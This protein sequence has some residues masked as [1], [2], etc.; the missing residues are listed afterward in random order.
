MFYLLLCI[1]S[2]VAPLHSFDRTDREI[3]KQ[4]EQLA[5]NS[6][7]VLPQLSSDIRA[8]RIG[9]VMQKVTISGEGVL[10]IEQNFICKSLDGTE[11][12]PGRSSQRFYLSDL[13]QK[14]P[15]K[16]Y[17]VN[18][19]V[20]TISLFYG[21]GLFVLSF[22]SE[23]D[24]EKAAK[25]LETLVMRAPQVQR[26]Q[27]SL[28]ELAKQCGYKYLVIAPRAQSY[29]EGF[30]LLHG[31]EQSPCL[32]S[33]LTK[34]TP[35]QIGSLLAESRNGLPLLLYDISLLDT[36][37]FYTQAIPH[38]PSFS[39][40]TLGEEMEQS[41][42]SDDMISLR[43]FF[44]KTPFAGIR[45]EKVPDFAAPLAIVCKALERNK[46]QK[47]ARAEKIQ[48]HDVTWYPTKV[49]HDEEIPRG[50]VSSWFTGLHENSD[51]ILRYCL[52]EEPL[53]PSI[54]SGTLYREFPLLESLLQCKG[55]YRKECS[56]FEGIVATSCAL[57][58]QQHLLLSSAI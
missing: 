44:E 49:L 16:R 2:V 42:V 6:L 9:P 39:T 45:F 24:L 17:E 52:L 10:T 51:D 15:N 26:V 13:K 31:G 37:P 34:H 21:K 47:Y 35:D 1:I 53:V 32:L 55:R 48:T 57:S 20:N 27:G 23:R 30:R 29:A 38:L 58:K 33:W 46:L 3:A 36:V 19:H 5:T 50:T 43:A 7:G 22:S 11:K 41:V 18:R 54:F 14:T 4:F 8:R 56:I 40:C 28:S 25:L 12:I